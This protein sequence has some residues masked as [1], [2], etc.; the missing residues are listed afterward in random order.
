VIFAVVNAK[1][2]GGYLVPERKPHLLV[3]YCVL[4][5]F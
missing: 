2:R 4:E 5:I 1:L 3:K